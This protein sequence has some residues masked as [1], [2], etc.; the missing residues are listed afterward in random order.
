M[1]SEVKIERAPHRLIAPVLYPACICLLFAAPLFAA[2]LPVSNLQEFN[3]ALAKAAPGDAIVLRSGSYTDLRLDFKAQ[4]TEASP[5]TLRAETPGSVMFG[6]K[7][8]L[9]IDGNWLVV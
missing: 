6:G 5:I 4:G 8:Q 3:Q 1:I 9:I 7:S 2:E